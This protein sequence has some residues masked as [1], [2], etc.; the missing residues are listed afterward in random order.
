MLSSP[1]LT[2]TVITRREEI[3]AY[4]DSRGM[5]LTKVIVRGKLGNQAALLKYFG[6]YLNETDGARF[7]EL[8][9][10][11][12]ALAKGRLDAPNIDAARE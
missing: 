5:E 11:T 6:K 10:L 7:D 2:A 12:Q 4:Y 9:R 1:M 3:A 8:S